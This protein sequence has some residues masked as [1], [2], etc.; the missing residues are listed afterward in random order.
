MCAQDTGRARGAPDPPT[1]PSLPQGAVS[2]RE[3]LAQCLGPGLAVGSTRG[4]GR[5]VIEPST[6]LPLPSGRKSKRLAFGLFSPHPLHFLQFSHTNFSI[7]VINE[8]SGPP[9]SMY[10]TPLARARC[11]LFNP[12]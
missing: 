2:Q 5:W 4:G 12:A 11:P 8:V 7:S 10:F 1:D 9:T 6:Y 3:V